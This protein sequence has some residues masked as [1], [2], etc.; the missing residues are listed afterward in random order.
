M[1]LDQ[2]VRK[3]SDWK[4]KFRSAISKQESM[5]AETIAKDNCCDLGKWLHNDGKRNFAAGASL[6]ECVTMHAAFHVEAG[7]VA[8]AINAKKFTTAG[9]MI[10]RNSPY[11]RASSAVVRAILKLKAEVAVI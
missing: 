3:H 6:S 9:T 7:K 10:D 5:D 1:D 8:S 2:A 4:I 11:A